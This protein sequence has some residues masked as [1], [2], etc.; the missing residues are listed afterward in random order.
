MTRR[1]MQLLFCLL[2]A[3]FGDAH[4]TILTDWITD[5]V[6]VQPIV[7]QEV[8]MST[9]PHAIGTANP[10]CT[11]ENLPLPG[12]GYKP[13]VVQSASQ[14]WNVLFSAGGKYKHIPICGGPMP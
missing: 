13:P 7:Q 9:S 6:S 14:L 10:H 8:K 2:R 3:S 5:N 12:F 1:M 11:T 4:T